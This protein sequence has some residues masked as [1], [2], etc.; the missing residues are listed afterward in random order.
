MKNHQ[1]TWNN[2]HKFADQRGE[3]VAQIISQF[4]EIKNK[5][6]L[7]IGCGDGGTAL[8][9]AQLGTKVTAIDIRS[10][11]A[12]KFKNTKIKFHCGSIDDI[13]FDN[14]KFDIVILQDVLEHVPD[15]EATIKKIRTLLSK[16]GLIYISTPNRFSL[17]NLFCDPHWNLPFVALFSRRWVRLFV[18]DIFRKDRRKREDWAALLSLF[19]LK[20]IMNR[21]QLEIKFV[22]FYVAKYLFQKPKSIVCKPSHIKLIYWMKRSGLELLVEKNVNDKFGFFNY[23]INPTWYIIAKLK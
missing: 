9:L 19:R 5:Q 7:E 1:K 21:N 3:L 11:L 4:T 16:T 14:I 10:D 17:L 23:L 12:E 15:P 22:N 20:K 18:K 13:S 8:K 2:Y 6:I